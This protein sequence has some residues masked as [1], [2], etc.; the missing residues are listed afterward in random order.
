MIQLRVTKPAAGSQPVLLD[1][2]DEDLPK[3]TLSIEDI[4]TTDTTTAFTRNFRVPATKTNTEFFETAFDVNGYDFNIST[5]KPAELLI[6]GVL[7]KQGELRLQQVYVNE[8]G[9]KIDYGVLFLGDVRDF[10]STL[11]EQ[12]LC[13]LD[14]S[15]LQHAFNLEN[16][17]G[18]WQA[19]PQGNDFADGLVNGDVIYPL[20][21]FG[22]TY[23]D[24]GNAEQTLIQAKGSGGG[25]TGKFIHN[26]SDD[27]LNINR[28]R[29]A[30]RVDA[31]LDKIFENAGYTY[32]STFFENV[33]TKNLYVGAFGDS[34][35]LTLSAF[36]SAFPTI[37][38]TILPGTG[39]PFLID[40]TSNGNTDN[41]D[42]PNNEFVAPEAALYTLEFILGGDLRWTATGQETELE[43]IVYKRSGGVLDTL[44]TQ[45][46]TFTS[47][48][49]SGGPSPVIE[50]EE[51]RVRLTGTS[52][53]AGDEIYAEVSSDATSDKN[54]NVDEALTRFNVTTE[55]ST[56]PGL[57]L[58]CDMKQIDFVK[59]LLTKFRLVMA[60]DKNNP[61]NFI[62]EPWQNY[63]STGDLFDWT[64]KLDLKKDIVLTPLLYTQTDRVTFTDKKGDDFLHKL[65]V[66]D[67]GEVY[68]AL[69]VDSNSEVVKGDR[70]VKT[71]LIIPIVKE[72]PE[73]LYQTI[74]GM[75]TTIFPQIHDKEVTIDSGGDVIIKNNP[76]KPGV[77]IFYY[78]GL[79]ETGATAAYGDTWYLTDDAVSAVGFDTYPMVSQF[80]TF[81]DANDSNYGPNPQTRCLG[82]QREKS[83]IDH[84]LLYYDAM[85]TRGI[86]AYTQYWSS[87]FNILYNPFSRRFTAYFNLNAA[88]LL[89]FSFDD[90]IF[91]KNAYYYVE[92]IYDLPM[93]DSE[94]VKVDLIKLDGYY[95][96]LS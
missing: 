71:N 14:L 50:V 29:P 82:W 85:E 23:D 5:R 20:I 79:K 21:D 3:L 95:P 54:F 26:V 70:T 28:L 31:V 94:S 62:L 92:R 59:D 60:T 1:L 91:V 44:A 51:F 8:E 75:D 39:V 9:D 66:E 73:A 11:G 43:M 81:G 38:Y 72:I 30:V 55:P 19:Y 16:V 24:S 63:I 90:V 34:T 76:V 64:D 77:N 67:N 52:L 89:A 49:Q 4:R 56:N 46:I 22:N 87:Y 18:S 13:Q 10:A 68:N 57:S 88:D 2:Y 53:L 7:F 69:N 27:W 33:L 80:Q 45:N 35:D 47:T 17:T 65:N 12:T 74:D 32:T 40:T 15:N 48:F 41:W 93:G 96:T 86:G 6:D 25:V 78:N 58:S 37:G 61:N 84:S 42:I 36:E 83:Y